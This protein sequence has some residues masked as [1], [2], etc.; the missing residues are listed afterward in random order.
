MEGMESTTITP[1]MPPNNIRVDKHRNVVKK[2]ISNSG[3]NKNSIGVIV[4]RSSLNKNRASKNKSN[5]KI[6]SS[7]S[8]ENNNNSI[9]IIVKRSNLNK[10][11]QRNIRNHSNSNSSSCSSIVIEYNKIDANNQTYDAI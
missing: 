2:S 5:S 1:P 6:S 10:D 3:K 7:S 4:R 9:G 11:R 8:K